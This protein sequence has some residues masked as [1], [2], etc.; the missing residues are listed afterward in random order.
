MHT[1]GCESMREPSD[2]SGSSDGES[3]QSLSASASA[4]GSS[5]LIDDDDED[6]EGFSDRGAGRDSFKSSDSDD[7]F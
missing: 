5:N 2:L 3:D 7:D 4:S 1:C 6:S